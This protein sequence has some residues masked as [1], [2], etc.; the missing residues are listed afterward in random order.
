MANR[1][2]SVTRLQSPRDSHCARELRDQNATR[3]YHQFRAE[4]VEYR[5][6]ARVGVANKLWESS[7]TR[8]RERISADRCRGNELQGRA[9]LPVRAP[10]CEL[11]GQSPEVDLVLVTERVSPKTV[12]LVVMRAA[13]ADAEDVMRPLTGAGI[14]S[15]AQMGKVDRAGIATL[16]A[17]AM[18]P[19]PPPVP[20]PDL[21][22]GCAHAQFPPLQPVGQPHGRLSDSNR[23]S[24]LIRG[25]SIAGGRNRS[26]RPGRPSIAQLNKLPF[27]S[28]PPRP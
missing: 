17:A 5:E 3:H 14:S 9:H 20:R 28:R 4:S 6:G 23:S 24:M 18:R 7:C 26:R 2:I 8:L 22:Q 1:S 11:R 21:L 19:Y 13:E 25:V 15:R 12:L 16:D 10:F 27:V